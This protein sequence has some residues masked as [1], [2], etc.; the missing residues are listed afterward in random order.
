[1]SNLEKNMSAINELYP[2]LHKWINEQPDN[3]WIKRDG[4]DQLYV[5][6]GTTF[7]PMYPPE[8]PLHSLEQFDLMKWNKENVTVIIGIGI[9][10]ALNRI[11]SQIE[12]GHHVVVIE[13]IGQIYRIAFDR[14]DFSEHIESHALLFA[15]TKADADMIFSHLEAYKVIEDWNIF[16]ELITRTRPEYWKL[17]DYVMEVLNQIQCNIGTVTSAGGKIA[18]ND[19]ATLPYVIRY[20]G[21]SELINLFQGKP[22]ICVSTGPSLERNI[23]LLKDI[24]DKVIIIAVGQA[25]RPLLAYDIRPDFICTVDFGEV[26]FTH[27]AGICDET[28]PLVTINK[29]YAPLLKAYK[30]HKFISASVSPKFENTAH[31]ALKDMGE[32]AQGGSVAHMAFG[33][34]AVLGCS[35]IL[36][37]GQ[38]LALE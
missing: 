22:A 25:L 12:K 16:V 24:Q 3:D 6:S 32:L 36:F 28:V 9:G 34:A 8:N 18:D 23:H 37:I 26:N 20:R 27:F 5:S 10:H 15:P 17:A 1:M 31:G 30:G 13:P 19:I 7:L 4:E 11:L 14:Y 38:N 29:T 2:E 33:L 21:V 35:P